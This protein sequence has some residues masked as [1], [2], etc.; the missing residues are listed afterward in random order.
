MIA[1]DLAW[2]TRAPFPVPL[3]AN[4]TGPTIFSA[5]FRRLSW[6]VVVIAVA[7]LSLGHA[8]AQQGVTS[9][10]I[11]VKPVLP[12]PFFETDAV[13]RRPSLNGTIELQGGMAFG[14][15]VRVGLT[16]MIGLETGISQI[17]RRFAFAL[18]NDTSGYTE[19]G[20]VRYVGYE[21]P[22][23]ALIHL[24]LGEKSYMN[25]ALGFSADLYPSDVQQELDE[26]FVYVFRDRWVQLGV[27]GNL[28]VE[29][30][31]DKAGIFYLGATFHR[32]FGD[33]AVADL[34]YWDVRRNFFPYPMRTGLN[35]SY[36]TVDLRYYFHE[37][38]QRGRKK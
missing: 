15:C 8:Q 18:H 2:A 16:K 28:G 24:R 4:S 35:G 5:M 38:P 31:T 21:I 6:S 36:L 13:L 1:A 7:C 19:D 27:V 34:T 25:A 33:M 11:Q 12:M 10:G 14:M 20:L 32:P 17:Q 30:R 22:I 23:T 9:F 37:D 29:Y 26:G 3:A